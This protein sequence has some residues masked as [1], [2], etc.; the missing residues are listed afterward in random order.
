MNCIFMYNPQSG[1]TKIPKKLD[2]IESEL[3]KKFD[4]VIIYAT[5]SATDTLD[6]AKLACGKYDYLIFSGGDGT[7][8][9]VVTGIAKEENRPILGYIPSGTANDISKNLLLSKNVKKAINAIVTG[10]PVAHDI[11]TVNDRYFM[12]V[13]AIGL[14]TSVS[15]KTK[16]KSKKVLGKL[17]YGFAGIH[18]FFHPKLYNVKLTIDDQVVER[19]TPLLLIL[20][21]I[22]TGGMKFNKSG[23]MNNGTFDVIVVKKGFCRGLF[24]VVSVFLR[25]MLGIPYGRKAEVFKVSSLN[26]DVVEEI[27]WCIDGEEGFPGSINIG[28]LHDHIQV[29]VPQK[30][31]K[32]KNYLKYN[33]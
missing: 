20:N 29:V 16:R 3:K 14:F 24:K 25:G 5:T 27:T 1:K 19:K 23:H 10:S 26:V 7:F 21:S 17:A 11:G 15:Y 18:D 4:E 33:K 32:T 13:T 30:Y 2:Y 8:N 22:S 12:Y 31:F 6:K 28:N 9:D